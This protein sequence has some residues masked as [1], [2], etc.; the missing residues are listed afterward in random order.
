MADEHIS[1]RRALTALGASTVGMASTLPEENAKQISDNSLTTA[2]RVDARRSGH[3]TLRR[4]QRDRNDREYVSLLDFCSGSEDEDAS[5]GLARALSTALELGQELYVP[6]GTYRL[7]DTA[8]ITLADSEFCGFAM[9]GVGLGSRFV[10][11]GENNKPMFHLIA[12]IGAGWYSKIRMSR[13]HLVG[14]SFEGDDRAGVDGIVI[15]DTSDARSGIC[16]LM[17]EGM[18]IRRIANGI[19][20]HHESDE[21]TVFDCYIEKFTDHGIFNDAGGSNWTIL[22]NHISDGSAASIGIR[23]ALASNR[24]IANT[25]Q[26]QRYRTAIQIDGGDR[27]G[28]SPYVEGNYIECQLDMSNGI[29]LSGV[30]GGSVASNVFKGC[31]GAI[32]IRL[33]SAP[34]GTPCRN[35]R[36][37]GHTHHLSGGYPRSFAS[38]ESNSVNCALSD[39]LESIGPGARG[40]FTAG[41]IEGDFSETFQDGV[42]APRGLN[43]GH[44]SLIVDGLANKADFGVSVQPAKDFKQS[45]GAPNRRWN[46]VMTGTLRLAAGGEIPKPII[47]CLQL[48]FDKEDS[49]LKLVFPD[50]TMHAVK[51]EE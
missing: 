11:E 45:L 22:S 19:R 37:G 21:V 28:Q 18:T 7:T 25:I 38:A 12:K 8:I 42:R 26:G 3:G 9:R 33:E 17:L 15:G 16:N 48:Y 39:N 1:R 43:V 47:D 14:N 20:A 24:I 35:I 32:L 34:D 23:V 13:L 49:S 40:S 29:L 6:R 30:Q 5:P 4:T 50:G 2:S 36:I 51:T 10:W 27:H 46:S 31:R 41:I 44:G